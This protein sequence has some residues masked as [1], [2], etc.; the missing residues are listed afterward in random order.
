MPIVRNERT[1]GE[2]SDRLTR[3]CDAM[4]TALEDDPEYQDG[5]HV[6]IFISRDIEET[7]QMQGG[8]VLHGYDDDTDALTDVF[9]HLAAIFEAN[10]MK[11]M[12]APLAQG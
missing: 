2:P 9:A 11:L 8:L 6:V 1:E 5:D 12:L 10:G 7:S 4:V 3:L